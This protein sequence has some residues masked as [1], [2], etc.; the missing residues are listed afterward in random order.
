MAEKRTWFSMQ[1]ATDGASADIAIYDVVGYYGVDAGSFRDAL[2]ALPGTVATINLRIN[3]PGGDVYQGVAI[4]NML[5]RHVAD[6]IVTVDGLAASIASFI[7]MAGKQILMPENAAMLIHNPSGGAYGTADDMDQMAQ[8]LRSIGQGVTNT[9]VTANRVQLP[10][11][12]IEAMLSAE[13]WLTAQEAVDKGFADKVVAPSDLS[14]L[15]D[16]EELGFTKAPKALMRKPPTPPVAKWVAAPADAINQYRGDDPTDYVAAAA[17][18]A[19]LDAAGFKAGATPEPAKARP[20]FL[21][22]NEAAPLLAASYRFP[23]ATMVDGKVLV[24]A[25]A[26][27]AAEAA[28]AADADIADP[29]K[30]A[31]GATIAGHRQA[32]AILKANAPPSDPAAAA[33]RLASEAAATRSKEILAACELAGVT[34]K[35]AREFVD[36][37]KSLEEVRA[38]LLAAGGPGGPPRVELNPHNPGGGGGNDPNPNAG[39]TKAVDRLNAQRL[40][41][42]RAHA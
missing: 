38:A 35:V 4:H 16:L 5:A 21:F 34:A 28:V 11:A 36:G 15:F 12:E 10:R 19:I 9:Y 29:E 14:M 24:T 17:A 41:R 42:Q 13:T 1:A 20:G 31:A 40:P 27:A 26:L 25:A 23:I 2:A 32:L 37:G 7:A 3:S 6:V 18:T 22:Q 8:W 30:V 33:A 39:W